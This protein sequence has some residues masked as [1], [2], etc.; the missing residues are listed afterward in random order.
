M[1][2]CYAIYSL[3]DVKRFGVVVEFTSRHN[4]EKCN[5]VSV[6]GPCQGIE[7]DNFVYWLYHCDI[8]PD[9]NWLILSDF[10]FM[11]SMGNKNLPGGDI[12]DMFL[13]NEVIGL[14]GLLEIPIKGRIYTW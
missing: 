1:V 7:R 5:L 4:L 10:N 14:P 12:N 2:F 9:E 11:R 13:F 3:I 8:P 6:Y